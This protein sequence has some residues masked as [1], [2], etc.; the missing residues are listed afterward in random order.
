MTFQRGLQTDSKLTQTLLD[1]M[2][3]VRYHMNT[4][5]EIER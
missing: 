5:R 2:P 4:K 1:I 3:K